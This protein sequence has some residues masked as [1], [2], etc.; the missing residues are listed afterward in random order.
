MGLFLFVINFCT[1]SFNH[2]AVKVSA[3][4]ECFSEY[5]SLL[6]LQRSSV[7]RGKWSNGLFIF[8]I[9]L[10]SALKKRTLRYKRGSGHLP[11]N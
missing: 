1:D 5:I 2:I 9:I 11:E 3:S 6:V 7:V 4:I 10:F 8:L